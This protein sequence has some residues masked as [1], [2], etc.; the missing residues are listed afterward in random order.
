MKDKKIKGMLGGIGNWEQMKKT[1][2]LSSCY[3][4]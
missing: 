1:L 2:M 4:F 3:W